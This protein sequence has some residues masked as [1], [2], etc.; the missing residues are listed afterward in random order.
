MNHSIKTVSHILLL[1]GSLTTLVS[2]AGVVY[3]RSG[4]V[5]EYP[6]AF[7]VAKKVSLK[8]YR[9]P[10]RE[11]NADLKCTLDAGHKLNFAT[12]TSIAKTVQ[13]GSLEAKKDIQFDA[14][15]PNDGNPIVVSVKA[16][17]E[18]KLLTYY[19]EGFCLFEH[20]GTQYEGFCPGNSDRDDL[21]TH[22]EMIIE[23]W[24]WASC[25]E[26]NAWFPLEYLSAQAEKG[27]LKGINPWGDGNH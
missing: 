7:Q 4:G 27:I 10:L 21:L 18:I 22:K 2:K 3:E 9:G 23:E 15:F 20:G 19:S 14:T 6:S 17:D 16:K 11:L 5:G 1:I 26:N 25:K 12:G 24:V 8:G 13:M